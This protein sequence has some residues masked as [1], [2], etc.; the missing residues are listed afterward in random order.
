MAE[1]RPD[2][3]APTPDSK[4]SFTDVDK[5]YGTGPTE[6]S[7][8]ALEDIDLDVNAGEAVGLGSRTG[9][10][11]VEVGAREGGDGESDGRERGEA[12]GDARGHAEGGQV[13]LVG[14][15]PEVTRLAR[16]DQRS[17]GPV[18]AGPIHRLTDDEEIRQR[19]GRRPGAGDDVDDGIVERQG[20]EH[21]VDVCGVDVVEDVVVEAVADRFGEGRG[22]VDGVGVGGV[23][24]VQ[25]RVAVV[26]VLAA[27]GDAFVGVGDALVQSRKRLAGETRFGVERVAEVDVHR[28]SGGTR[29]QNGFPFTPAG[30]ASEH[31]AVARD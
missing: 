20:V 13:V 11:G 18:D 16:R 21:G 8:V 3:G 15:V 2:T 24:Q 22:R 1:A 28:E 27:P 9:E 12:A 14:E 26:G 30:G 6:E 10:E 23:G 5:I 31:E 29:R 17:F 7:V 4:I 25:R 19:L